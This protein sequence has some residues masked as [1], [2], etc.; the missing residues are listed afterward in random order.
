[1]KYSIMAGIYVHIPFC[2]SICHYCDFYRTAGH[3]NAD[4][5]IDALEKEMELRAGYLQG[6]IVETLY[7]G[8][9]TPSVLNTHHLQRIFNLISCYHTLWKE[10]E[11]T[12]EVNPDDTTGE[13]LK[14]LRDDTPVNRLSIGI[15]SFH[16]PDLVRMNRRHTAKQGLQSIE[17]AIQ[18]GFSNISVDLIYGMPGSSLEVL[19]SSLDQL[20]AFDIQHISAYHL[21][22]EPGTV[23]FKKAEKGLIRP[24]GEEESFS[25]FS[26]LIHR[27]GQKGFV[28]YEISNWAKKGYL[29]RHN[30]GYWK[31]KPYLGLGPSAHSYNIWSRQWNVA[32][33]PRYLQAIKDG[34]PFYEREMLTDVMRFN[35]YL[36]TSLRTIWGIDLKEVRTK[37]GPIRAE[38]LQ[39]GCESW[40][41]SGHMIK[42]EDTITLTNRGYFISD[43]VV[44]NLMREEQTGKQA[45]NEE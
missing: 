29:S 14:A 12:M 17:Q 44:S 43:T 4:T 5:Y 37:F 8:G 1:M 38:T 31:R 32:S 42:T 24:A 34:T 20:F 39:K 40:I 10:C 21:T 33:L 36:L 16:D 19:N 7:F 30:T 22:I 18:Q 13:Y 6:E 27:L 11:I 28:H 23:F 3:I 15:Q 9:G 26:T 35:E 41:H 25:Q 2:R 45:V